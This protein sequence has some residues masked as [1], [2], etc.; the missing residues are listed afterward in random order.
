VRVCVYTAIYGGYDK[1][2]SV[3]EQTVDA[4]YVCFTESRELEAT[5]PWTIVRNARRPE[6]HPRMRAK[7]FKVLSHRVFPGGRASLIEA[8]SWRAR[9]PFTTYDAIV[10]VDGSIQIT[11]PKFVERMIGGIGESGWCMWKHPDRD[12][13]LDE[14]K[15]STPMRKYQ[16]LPLEEQVASYTAE[17]FP[18]KAGLMACTLI[19]RRARDRRLDPIHEAWWAEN[20]RWSYQDQLSLPVVL[21]RAGHGW[22]VIDENLWSNDLMKFGTHTSDL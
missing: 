4:D 16:G 10:W 21:W 9:R 22:D 13:I 19:G 8:P 20:L 12:C 5:G 15:A 14:V 6:L 3:P 11:S 2:K 7:F 17:G 18:A 1:L